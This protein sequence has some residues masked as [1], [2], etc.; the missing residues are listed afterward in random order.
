MKITQSLLLSLWAAHAGATRFVMYIDEYHN[1]NLPDQSQT[2][3]IDHVIMGFAQST[4]FNTSTPAAYQPFE[5]L[6]TMRSRFAPGTKVMIAIGGW[7]D[8]AGFSAG[9]KDDASRAQYAKNVAAMLDSVGADGVDIDWEYPGG[10]GQ[11]Y[12]QIPNSSKSPEIQNYP[13]FLQAIRNAI[14]KDKLLSIAVPGLKRD[15]IA[16]T[17][18]QGPKIWP[19]VDFVNIMS[20]DLINRRDNVT[21]HHTS[22]QGSLESIQNYLDIGLD[23]A[24]ANLGFAY[25]AKYFTTDPSSDCADHPIGCALVPLENPDGSDNL[26]S[27]ALTFEKANM[28]PPPTNLAT[29]TDGTCGYDKGT[30]CPAGMCCSQSGYCGTTPD[31]CAAGCNS[32]YGS[33]S[34]VSITDSWRRAQSNGRTDQEAGGQYYWDGQAN[35]FW[36]WDTPALMA[37]KFKDIVAAKKLGGVM[38]W[39][40]GEDSF[41]WSHV[42]AMRVGVSSYNSTS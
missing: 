12:K 20:Y 36:T 11:D 13:L 1:K 41:D 35:L 32:D 27:G 10:N 30:K 7:G 34:G 21:G 18:E 40:L 38:A 25:Y 4:L 8:T 14:G 6:S 37:R 29:S 26:K 39:S 22:V 23:P 28:A 17:P 31:Y 5:P 2:G 42:N 3:G 15:M 24:K 33:C 19:S 9:S 16:F